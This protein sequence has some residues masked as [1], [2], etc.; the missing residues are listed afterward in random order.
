[1][2][3]RGGACPARSTRL[4]QAQTINL[5]LSESRNKHLDARLNHEGLFFL[6][7]THHPLLTLSPQSPHPNPRRRRLPQMHRLPVR[8]QSHRLVV[9]PLQHLD[10][11][12][13]PQLQPFQKLQ[14]LPILLVNA[15]NFR[16]LIRPQIRQQ[17]CPLASQLRH[18]T[19]HRYAMRARFLIPESLQQKRLD[20][21]RN[22]MLQPL[23]FVV[24]F[25]PRKPNH[26]RKQHFRELVPQ[27]QPLRHHAALCV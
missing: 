17:D 4:A 7:T 6:L 23:R 27:S 3:C 10:L 12:R 14:K 5:L 15:K 22:P 2:L 19:P 25:R 18:A 21:R 11:R 8:P 20:F 16:V 13:R 24:R 1:M 26:F 9:F